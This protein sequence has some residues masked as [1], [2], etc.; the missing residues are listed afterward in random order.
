[1]SLKLEHVS[2]LYG[3]DTTLPV[4]ALDDICMEIRTVSSSASS[5]IPVPGNPPLCSI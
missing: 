4:R 3:T 1:M 5:A 2:Y